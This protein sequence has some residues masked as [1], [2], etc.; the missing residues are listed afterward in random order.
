MKTEKYRKEIRVNN[1]LNIRLSIRGKGTILYGQAV[2][3]TDG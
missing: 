2:D 3:A 1:N